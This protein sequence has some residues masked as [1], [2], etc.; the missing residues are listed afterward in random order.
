MNSPPRST[1]LPALTA[2]FVTCLVTAN[3]IAVKLAQF[4]PL[5]VPAGIVIFPLSYLFGDVLTEVYGYAVTRRVIWLGFACNLLAVVAIALAGGLPSPAFWKGQPAYE[6]ILGAAPRLL[7]ASFVAYLIGEF[8]NSFVLAR[9]KVLTS[10]RWLWTRTIPSTF[11][12]QG[13]DSLVFVALAFGGSMA[14]S[15]LAA[16]ILSQW[17]LKTA[18][19]VVA[20]PLT[21]AVVNALKRAEGVDYFDR[22]TDFSPLSLRG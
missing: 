2:L 11:V 17:L 1:W 13:V 21:Y 14:G 20:T 12:G 9:L 4:G 22:D 19:E 7:V 6:Q 10:G 15:A 16:T 18:Y 5:I 8:L 3:I